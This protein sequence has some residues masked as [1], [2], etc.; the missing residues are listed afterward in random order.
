MKRVSRRDPTHGAGLGFRPEIAADLLAAPDVV[1]FV[2]VVAES[3]FVS[4]GARREARALAE[5]WPVV[6]HGVKLSLGSADGIEPARARRLGALARELGAPAVSEH[7][8]LTRGGR[9]EIGHLTAIPYT[10]E[11]VGVV[12]RNVARA[13]RELP[14]VPFLLENIAWTFRWPEDE[15]REGDFY[16]EVAEATGCDLLLDLANLYANALNSG[17]PPVDLLESY[18][19]EHVGMIHIAGGALVHGFYED[20]HAHPVPREV[21]GLLERALLRTGKVPVILER[22]GRFPA[23]SEIERELRA[24]REALEDAEPRDA[25]RRPATSPG[26][27]SRSLADRQE[28]LAG[29]LTR[30]EPPGPEA[31]GYGL[32]AIERTRAIL[33]EKRVDDA[34]P[35]LPSTRAAAGEELAALAR[36]ALAGTQRAPRSAGIVDARRIAEA[37]VA[38]PRFGEF[39]QRDALELRMRFAGS[40]PRLAPVLAK[41]TLPDGRR[42]WALKAPGTHAPIR[43]YERTRG[44]G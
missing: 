10:R 24:A 19:L 28:A 31:E 4:A 27:L 22:D 12:A 17:S 15:M 14:D 30:H 7:V 29:L 25:A 41:E 20:T 3:V 5:T 26:S 1:D 23:F 2:E 44:E 11:A 33:F 16:A 42:L 39:A 13:R 34:I 43:I 32:R 40:R 36:R 6:P 8:A 35:L 38:H 9:R 21:I 37:L 18:P